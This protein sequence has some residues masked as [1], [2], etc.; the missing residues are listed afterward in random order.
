MNPNVLYD[1]ETIKFEEFDAIT[2]GTDLY[3]VKLIEKL[4]AYF[5]KNGRL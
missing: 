2:N 5:K 1:L 4:E 3:W